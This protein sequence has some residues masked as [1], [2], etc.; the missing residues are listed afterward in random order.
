MDL[1]SHLPIPAIGITDPS[2][3]PMIPNAKRADQRLNARRPSTCLLC[4]VCPGTSRRRGARA[5][6]AARLMT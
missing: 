5:A 3:P 1:Q 6:R 2:G 4:L